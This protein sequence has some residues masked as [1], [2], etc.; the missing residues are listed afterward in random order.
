MSKNALILFAAMQTKT[1][2]SQ[3]EKKYNQCS[4]SRGGGGRQIN[5]ISISSA[6]PLYFFAL[7]PGISANNNFSV[8]NRLLQSYFHL[9]SSNLHL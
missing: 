3:S 1:F 8:S 6:S 4:I 5:N 2:I 9:Q 7:Y